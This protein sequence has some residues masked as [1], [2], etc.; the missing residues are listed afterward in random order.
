[1]EYSVYKGELKEC[2]SAVIVQTFPLTLMVKIMLCKFQLVKYKPWH[3]AMS[4]AWNDLEGTPEVWI[5]KYREF[6]LTNVAH[7]NVPG[8]SAS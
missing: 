1:M 7:Q 4:N 6:L 3:T 5:S 8:T 2:S